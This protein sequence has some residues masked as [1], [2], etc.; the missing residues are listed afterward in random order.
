MLFLYELEH[1]DITYFQICISAPLSNSSDIT[2]KCLDEF[3]HFVELHLK[4]LK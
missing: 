1:I 2:D 4:G 3:D